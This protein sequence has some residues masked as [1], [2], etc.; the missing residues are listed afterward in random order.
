MI[1]AMT[2][3][4]EYWGEKTTYSLFRGGLGQYGAPKYKQ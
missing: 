1:L 2:H 3:Q 4:T